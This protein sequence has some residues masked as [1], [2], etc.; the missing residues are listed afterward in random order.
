[1]YLS[2]FQEREKWHFRLILN[3]TKSRHRTTILCISSVLYLF[4][5]IY[6]PYLLSFNASFWYLLLCNS[7]DHVQRDRTFGTGSCTQISR[8]NNYT[9]VLT[10]KGN[11]HT[12]ARMHA[13]THTHTRPLNGTKLIKILKI[14]E[15]GFESRIS[16][17]DSCSISDVKWQT[18]GP[19]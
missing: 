3:T 9:V 2:H 15:V 18:E 12:H 6:S 1:M 19:K 5:G 7:N 4:I 16:S 8:I 17:I 14:G 11:T 13:C 10:H